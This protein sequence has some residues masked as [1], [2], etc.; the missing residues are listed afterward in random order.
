MFLRHWHNVLV[1]MSM[2]LFVCFD[3]RIWFDLVG[4]VLSCLV[5]SEWVVESTTVTHSSADW[6]DLLLP[7]T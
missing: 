3:Q 1:E 7:L 2:T 4:L 6:W 5:L